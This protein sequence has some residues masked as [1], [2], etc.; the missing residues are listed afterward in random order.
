MSSLSINVL[1]Y[2]IGVTT[3]I[4]I[5]VLAFGSLVYKKFKKDF[6]EFKNKQVEFDQAI[7]TTNDSLIETMKS[8]NS[9]AQDDQAK[10]WSAIDVIVKEITKTKD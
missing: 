2:A 9:N 10:T 7:T 4:L 5:G 1:F 6:N 8:L 3:G